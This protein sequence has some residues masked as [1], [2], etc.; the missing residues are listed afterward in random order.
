MNRHQYTLRMINNISGLKYLKYSGDE[1]IIL[2]YVDPT[3]DSKQI[4]SMD[5]NM[6]IFQFIDPQQF[7][8]KTKSFGEAIPVLN[9][10]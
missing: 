8:K 3:L 1:K 4:D 2:V 5:E 7:E 9:E 10:G 6:E